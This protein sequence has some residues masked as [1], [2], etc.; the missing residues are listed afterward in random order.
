M[1][2]AT[3]TPPKETTQDK[4]KTG[5][6]TLQRLHDRHE[7]LRSEYWDQ[8]TPHEEIATQMCPWRGRFTKKTRANK[9][10]SEPKTIYDTTAF[11]AHRGMGAFL[12]GGGSSPARNWFRLTASDPVLSE[13]YSVREYHAESARRMRFILSRSNA[14]QAIHG[15]YEELTA[16]GTA[17]VLLERNFDSVIHMHVLTVGQYFLGTSPLGV[18]N[19]VYREFEMTVGQIVAEFGIENC[20]P[21][22]KYQHGEGQL[23]LLHTVVHAVEPREDRQLDK[24]DQL[25]MKFRSIYFMKGE[26]R[27]ARTRGILREGGYKVFPYL[28]PRWSVTDRNAWGFGP[29]HETLPHAKRLQKMQFAMGE[30]VAFGVKPP[31][32]G[33]AGLT[34]KEIKLRPGGYT[35]VANGSNQK[36]ETMFEV[37]LDINALGLQIENTQDQIQRALYND[38]FLLIMNSRR[39]KTATEVDELHEEKMLM[40][41]PALERLHNEFLRPLVERLF[42]FMDEAQLLPPRPSELEGEPLQVEFVS[43]LQQLQQA[44]GVQTLERFLTM[45]SA[46]GEVFPEMIDVVDPDQVARDYADMLAIEPDNLRDPNDVAQ[47]RQARNE[48]QMQ[49]AQAEAMAVNASA[50]RDVAAATRDAPDLANQFQGYGGI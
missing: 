45:V 38:L 33:P 15:V 37:N 5:E 21:E 6:W 18:V 31:L 12:M 34:Q 9:Q 41:G 22:I 1:A 4:R 26:R 29:G 36:I 39:A 2:S 44:S 11:R 48:A 46:G 23:E 49:Q 35:P 27:D 32:Q 30:A 8:R 24:S 10:V 43:M 16:F 14:Y 25:N 20:T 47:L 28:V 40:L 50:Q 19:T 42:G 3:V 13:V 7:R 17:C